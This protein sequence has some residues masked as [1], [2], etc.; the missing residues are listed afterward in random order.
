VEDGAL[1][2]VAVPRLQ[3]DRQRRPSPPRA[4]A[5]IRRAGSSGHHRS[6]LQFTD[7]RKAILG[8]YDA[9]LGARS[10]ENSGRGILARKQQG[11]L[12]NF[13]Y[14]DNLTR[15]IRH[16]G[17]ILIDLIPKIYDTARVLRIIGE[18]GTPKTQ[19]VNG[20]KLADNDPRKQGLKHMY[21]LGVGTYDVVALAEPSYATKRLE[22]VATQLELIKSLPPEVAANLLD[23]V[24]ANMDLPG[25]ELLVERL[26]K[27]LAPGLADDDEN[28]QP[29][30]PQ[31]KQKLNQQ[32]SR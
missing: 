13:H 9:Q 5:H 10:N 19:M 12:G 21:D 3:G 11:E 14:V 31:A 23:I 24:V 26:K 8:I 4:Q 17:R 32:A 16:R 7:K 29:I 30:P 22:A 6:G 15:A 2:S 27:M 25:G 20:S 28:A 18:D 1:K